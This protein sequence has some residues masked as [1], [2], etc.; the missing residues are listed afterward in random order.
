MS[1]FKLAKSVFLVIFE[2]TT[3]VAFYKSDFVAVLDK[4]NSN[5]ILFLL[6]LYVS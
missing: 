6:R 5:F 4:S 2:L 1:D 3:P